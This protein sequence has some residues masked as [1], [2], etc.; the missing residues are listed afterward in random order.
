MRRFKNQPIR[1]KDGVLEFLG[2][3]IIEDLQDKGIID[4]NMIAHEYSDEKYKQDHQQI[5][6]LL[7]HS[8]GSYLDLSCVREDKRHASGI[9]R[10]YDNV[11]ENNKK[12]PF[13]E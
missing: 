4:L 9:I 11:L 5:A 10:E 6:Q 3:R 7:G 12:S 1:M 2:N 8:L 13:D